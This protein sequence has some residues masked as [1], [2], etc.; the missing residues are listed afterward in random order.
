MLTLLFIVVVLICCFSV[1]LIFSMVK[2]GRGADEGEEKILAIMLPE[3]SYGTFK[4]L[5]DSMKSSVAMPKEN[6]AT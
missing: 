4:V 5:D 1:V 3:S 6:S 2:T